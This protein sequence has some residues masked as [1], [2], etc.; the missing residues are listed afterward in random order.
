MCFPSVALNLTLNPYIN[1]FQ[2]NFINEV[3]RA[4]EMERKLKF[5]QS[6]IEEYNKAAGNTGKQI[7]L[8]E[9]K[10]EIISKKSYR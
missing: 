4:D 9:V 1:A 8:A 10:E 6:Q 7:K 2:R 5:F 3:K